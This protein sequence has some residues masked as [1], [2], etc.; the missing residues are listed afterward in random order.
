M[1]LDLPSNLY[2]EL[3]MEA[4]SSFADTCLIDSQGW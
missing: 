2:I 1:S 3:H 4:E